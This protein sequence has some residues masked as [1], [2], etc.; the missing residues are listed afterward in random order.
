ML[1]TN[2]L[3]YFD[4][5][6]FPERGR[7]LEGHRAGGTGQ[8]QASHQEV[9]D[10][11]RGRSPGENFIKPFFLIRHSLSGKKMLLCLPLLRLSGQ[12]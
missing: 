2:A 5:L 11:H 3:A 8:L 12:A 1:R 6:F 7:G 9:G 4:E 10:L